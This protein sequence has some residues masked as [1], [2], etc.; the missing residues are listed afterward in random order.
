M[1]P[2]ARLPQQAAPLDAW[3]QDL[4]GAVGVAWVAI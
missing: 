4:L 3:P 2:L 1:N